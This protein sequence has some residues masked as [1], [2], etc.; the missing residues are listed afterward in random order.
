VPIRN[1]RVLAWR[2]S[3]TVD[4]LDSTTTGVGGMSALTN[5]VPDPT[6]RN[7][8]VP[9]SAAKQ[10]LGFAASNIKNISVF[11]ILGD[12][13]YGMVGNSSG[14]DFPFI[15]NLGTQTFTYPSGITLS[16]VPATQSVV[17]DW[18][19]PTMAELGAY[20]VVTHPGFTGAANG[21]I[22]WFDLTKPSSPKWK[23]GNTAV[24]PLVNVPISCCQFG[25]R[26]YYAVGN[27]TQASD[28]FNPIMIT[29]AN[30]ALTYGGSN[31]I[32]ALAGL[33]LNNQVVGGVVQSLI[34][35]KGVENIWQLTG[36]YTGSPSPWQLNTLNVATGTLA[37][38][39]VIPTPNGLAFIAPDGL[40]FI[41]FS[42]NI[43]DPVGEFGTG[44]SAPFQ[45]AV[46]PTRMCGDYNVQTIRIAVRLR[47]SQ[48]NQPNGQGTVEYWYNF[49]LQAWTGPHS[50]PTGFIRRYKDTFIASM[51]T[52]AA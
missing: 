34:V 40:R 28:E 49:G 46:A 36:D 12:I 33:G 16:N 5:L 25:G 2:P 4:S 27:A 22:G 37:P 26:I 1:S 31:P 29:N 51:L 14:Y 41:D 6:T 11:Y 30:Q 18:T 35:F 13:V 45:Q 21:F 10:V 15:Y 23:S 50:V 38:N 19:P 9:R 47:Q 48:P 39:A 44:V 3:G 17:G 7:L 42:G 43:S 52:Y 8:F 20:I 24:N 32:T